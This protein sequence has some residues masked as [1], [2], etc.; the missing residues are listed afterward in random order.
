MEGRVCVLLSRGPTRSSLVDDEAMWFL[1]ALGSPDVG[2]GVPFAS[3]SRRST[4]SLLFSTGAMK[5]SVEV[6]ASLRPG[7][8]S[9]SIVTLF[10]F[11]LLFGSICSCTNSSP[12]SC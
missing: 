4:R 5:S 9:H 1:P 12:V 8:S 3:T 2:G 6:A 10:S 11:P 7:H